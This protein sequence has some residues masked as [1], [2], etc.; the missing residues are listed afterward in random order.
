M[1]KRLIAAALVAI[2]PAT[3]WAAMN[4]RQS[5]EYG[6]ADWS[7]SQTF[8]PPG[9]CV[10]GQILPVTFNANSVLTQ[11]TVTDISNGVIT[12]AMTIQEGSSTGNTNLLIYTNGQQTTPMG[13]Y[14]GSTGLSTDAT[15]T[16]GTASAGQVNVLSRPTA[17][18][19]D[20]YINNVVERYQYIAVGSDGGGSADVTATVLL[21][22]C[23]R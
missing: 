9:N 20:R 13:I 1:M 10:G 23:P 12:N 18:G 17:V 21:R 3:A 14:S 15:L 11:Y 19:G 6:T 7:G 2:V 22:V 8:A 5:G 4:I 16:I